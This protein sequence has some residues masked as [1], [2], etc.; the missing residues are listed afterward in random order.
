MREAQPPPPA[1][2]RWAPPSSRHEGAGK[3]PRGPHLPGALLRWLPGLAVLVGILVWVD[4]AELGERLR[5]LSP[6]W[7][8]LALLLSVVQVTV[9]AWRW[10]FTAARL[11][12]RLPFR[13]ALTEYY[14]AGF[15]NQVLPGGVVG[16]ITRAWRHAGQDA[17]TGRA[18]R[19][20]ILERA[21]GQIIMT[22]V[23]LASAG[24]I[25]ARVMETGAAEEEGMVLLQ[26]LLT[27]AVT[28]VVVAAA[29]VVAYRF[30]QRRF[31]A[32][33]RRALLAPRAL[34]IQLGSS[35]LVVAT[36]LAV[37]LAAARAL[38]VDTPTIVLLP[39]VAPVLV[40]MLIPVTVAGWGVR[41]GAA[42]LIW[43]AVGLSAS[44]GVAI[45]V[46]YGLL[47]LLSALPGALVL[48]WSPLGRR[49]RGRFSGGPH[50]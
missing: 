48:L 1:P 20:V 8:V 21:S 13:R 31:R 19:A 28:A 23:A 44:E 47:V 18:I 22:A 43:A 42:A 26:W 6:G 4:G 7:V 15:L 41:E 33:I 3:P 27:A 49:T 25:L 2:D 11:G 16:D 40:A 14:L 35:A 9:S 29:G 10:K 36:Y 12:M 32:E 30:L 38:G 39:L 50:S 34:P 17:P 37:Y 24:L 46:A 5:N 45:S